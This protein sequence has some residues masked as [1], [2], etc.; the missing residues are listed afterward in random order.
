[1]T[2]EF[3]GGSLRLDLGPIARLTLDRPK[4]HNAMTAAM[5]AALPAI[6]DL[7]ISERTRVLIIRGSQNRA[8][9][10]GADIW[11]L[12]EKVG[13]SCAKDMLL[14]GRTV[15][16]QEALRIG[17]INRLENNIE[18]AS[19]A[20]AQHLLGL[21]PDAL[22]TIKSICNALS[23]PIY[24]PELQNSFEDTFASAEFHEGYHAFLEKRTPNFL[25]EGE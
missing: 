16:A 24:K 12:I 6:F 15:E 14:T 21:A 2:L 18:S 11:Q 17:L 22:R 19:T 1:M 3:A 7:L 23:D 20:L 13:I 4:K 8:F 5:W 25:V 10:A 9:C